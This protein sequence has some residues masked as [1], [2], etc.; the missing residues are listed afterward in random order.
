M[1]TISESFV[2]PDGFR[3]VVVS[4]QVSV[5]ADGD[6]VG[7]NDVAAQFRQ[8]FSNLQGA[9]RRVGGELRHV[10]K[11]TTYLTSADF[12]PTYF[13][14]RARH[15]L[16]WFGESPPA[17]TLLVVTR[18]GH[19]DFLIEVEAMAAIPPDR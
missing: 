15:F 9:M 14:E 19:E 10:I 1:S 18:L 7:L 2:V 4:G 16:D 13:D 5:D 12:L 11:C 3:L 6:V 8:A 17:N